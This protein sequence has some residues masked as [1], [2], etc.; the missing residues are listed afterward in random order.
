MMTPMMKCGHAAN[1]T[2]SKTG[3][4]VCVICLLISPG[5]DQIATAPD[6]TGRIAE[7]AYRGSCKDRVAK[8][9]DTHYGEFDKNG[10]SFAPSST[11]LPFFEYQPTQPTDKY[12]C[13]CFGWD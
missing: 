6:L 7:C 2:N 9:R 8:Y 13:G 12:F 10:H 5:A 11:D 1:G 4:L 3:E